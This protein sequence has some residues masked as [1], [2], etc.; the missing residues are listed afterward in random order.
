[1][2]LT[3]S[4]LP[5][6]NTDSGLKSVS[7]IV[8]ESSNVPVFVHTSGTTSR[9]KG[10]PLCELPNKAMEAYQQLKLG[11]QP[12]ENTTVSVL[13]A[14]TSLGFPDLGIEV[15]EFARLR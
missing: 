10:V 3:S 9:P 11:L 12:D 8:N 6:S 2:N 4:S 1:M 7:V 14:C 13:S 15:H 5:D